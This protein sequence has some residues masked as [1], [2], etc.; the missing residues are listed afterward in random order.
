MKINELIMNNQYEFYNY[1]AK[2]KYHDSYRSNEYSWIRYKDKYRN[3]SFYPGDYLYNISPRNGSVLKS[4]INKIKS[5]EFPGAIWVEEI[6]K[7]DELIRALDDSYFEVSFKC[8]AMHLKISEMKNF[9]INNENNEI[10][11]KLVNNDEL[12]KQWA[13]ILIKGWWTWNKGNELKLYE[14]Y[15]EIYKDT[16]KIRLYIA[17]Y[18]GNPAGTSLCFLSNDSVGLYLISTH[19][20]YRGKGI[21]KLLTK[22]PI[23]EAYKVGYEHAVLHGTEM[24]EIIYKQ[25]GFK[26]YFKTKSYFLPL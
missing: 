19:P 1:I 12:L 5:G 9:N 22:T 15:K 20:D 8:I 25:L 26:E 18:K 10:E 14:L 3:F 6:E 21:G 4:I 24:G 11:I 2:G 17:F 7:N 23:S 13:N 16:D